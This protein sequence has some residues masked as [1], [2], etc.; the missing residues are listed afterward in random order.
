MLDI[1]RQSSNP[2]CAEKNPA[3]APTNRF[4]RNDEH[5]SGR[6]IWIIENPDGTSA[7]RLLPV[8]I[9]R[10]PP[11]RTRCMGGSDWRID[12]YGRSRPVSTGDRN[13][14]AGLE[15]TRVPTANGRSWTV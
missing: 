5:F 4:Q 7:S 15:A 13:P 12:M 11:G 10:W 9:T 2:L 3:V 6:N 14:E 8:T 1:A